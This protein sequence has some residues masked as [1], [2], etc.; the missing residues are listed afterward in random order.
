MDKGDMV[1]IY[2]GVLFSHKKN[3]TIS[4]TATQ[5]DPEIVTLNEV[6]QT[7]KDISYKYHLHVESKKVVKMNLFT[8]QK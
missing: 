4:L 5:V 6:S 1:H 3:K 8:K 2:N 7:E